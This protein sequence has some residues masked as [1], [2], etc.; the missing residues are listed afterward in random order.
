MTI[1]IDYLVVGAGA[2][3]MA[4]ADTLVPRTD[5]DVVIVDRRHDPGGHWNDDYG[6][7]RLHQPSAYYGVDS[8]PLGADGIDASGPNAGFYERASRVEVCDYY[9]R[10]LEERLIPTGRVRFIP[11]TE[12]LG[13]ES[14]E[15]AI[16]S[17]LTGETTAVRVRRKVVDATYIATT[18]PSTHK[19]SFSIDPGVR[20]VAPNHLVRLEDPASAFTV[21]GAGKTSMDTVCWL[22]DQE[23][24]P[25]SI[26]WI[27]PRDPWIVDRGWMQSLTRIGSI[28]EWLA[29]ETEACAEAIDERDLL[30]RLEDKDVFRRLDPQ[31]EPSVFRGATLSEQEHAT[32]KSI[33]DVVRMGRVIHVG[34]GSVTLQQG[35]IPTRVGEVFVD[36]S[37]RGI[38]TPPT[39]PIFEP[40]RITLQRVQVGIDPFSPALIGVVEATDRAEE[41]KNR[42]CPPNRVTGEAGGV[43]SDLL[44][45]L[46]A[47]VAWF[48]E[49]DIWKWQANTRLSPFRDAR[50]YMTDEARASVN[51]LFASTAPAIEN[52]QRIAAESATRV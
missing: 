11:V 26:R 8:L 47:R 7:V 49:P 52:L 3:G 5:A 13:E 39:R 16:R 43:A 35:S 28:A 24:D 25:D 6:F 20:L 36:C 12:Y 44:I 51:R 14:G 40:G 41:E 37:A 10:V 2:S 46:T 19:P 27:R 23:V 34:M 45:T 18:I 15:H 32:I 42:L 30:S 38:G 21:I 29:R 1:E 22:V 17:V 9:R 50:L 31:I 48:G 33:G 4:F